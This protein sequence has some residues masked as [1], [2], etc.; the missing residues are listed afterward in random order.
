MEMSSR[1][2]NSSSA[3][4][5]QKTSKFFVSHWEESIAGLMGINGIY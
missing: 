4:S 2:V 3:L 1:P 5:E